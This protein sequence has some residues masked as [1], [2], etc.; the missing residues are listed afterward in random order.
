MFPHQVSF[1]TPTDKYLNW[2]WFFEINGRLIEWI[3]LVLV[4]MWCIRCHLSVSIE[5]MKKIF[6]LLLVCFSFVS[7]HAAPSPAKDGPSIG[8]VAKLREGGKTAAVQLLLSVFGAG[9]V[10][11]RFVRLRRSLIAPKGLSDRARKLWKE[12]RFAELEALGEKEPST[13]AR[14][15]S[16]IVLHRSAPLLDVSTIAGDMVSRELSGHH[17]RAYPMGVIATLEPLLGLLGMILGMI[18]T[19]ETVALAGALGDASQLAAGISEALVTTGLGLAIAIPFLSLYH[20]FKSRTNAFGS[21]LEE[22]L[23]VLISEWLMKKEVPSAS[24][25]VTEV[26]RAN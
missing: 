8:L 20:F 21:L 2:F 16:F 1:R 23:T 17:Q 19:F 14:V 13:L 26:A 25:V 18:G 7:L 6:C 22:E 9:Y 3:A 12:G 24:T 10:F 5:S 15:I 4:C 11:E